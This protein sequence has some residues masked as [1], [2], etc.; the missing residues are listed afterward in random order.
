M[1]HRW[2]Q[3]MEQRRLCVFHWQQSLFVSSPQL[4]NL[5]CRPSGNIPL[6]R[7]HMQPPS[8]PKLTHRI[9]L[10]C[11]PHT[12]PGHF[13]HESP[14]STHSH[15]THDLFT[16]CPNVFFI[17]VPGHT[18]E[19]GNERVDQA[20]KLAVQLPRVNPESPPHQRRSYPLL[21]PARYPTLEHA[22]A[23]PSSP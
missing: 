2:I 7:T 11:V 6:P 5:H 21:S 20:V 1:L 13:Y 16:G 14:C 10:P 4:L 3:T 15:P 17:W 18:G 22:M 8:N 9:W 12:N 23:K 19:R